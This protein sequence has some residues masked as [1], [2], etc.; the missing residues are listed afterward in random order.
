MTVI[1]SIYPSGALPSF[2]ARFHSQTLLLMRE[3]LIF[4]KLKLS[5]APE[6]SFTKLSSKQ[7]ED[8]WGRRPR[9]GW[10]RRVV[11]DTDS[12]W[13]KRT[14]DKKYERL[15]TFHHKRYNRR[16]CEERFTYI[17]RIAS[18][19]MQCKSFRR[20]ASTFTMS[21]KTSLTKRKREVEQLGYKSTTFQR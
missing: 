21:W 11:D 7:V 9:Q 13:G 2:L 10:R 18:F 5:P 4:S 3:E 14:R 1:I 16:L 12:I 17:L 8:W 15:E 6:K 19:E 20:P